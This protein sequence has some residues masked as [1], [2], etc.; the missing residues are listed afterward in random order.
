MV[1]LLGIDIGTSACKTAL[2]D[3]QG[4]VLA[5][6]TQSYPLF[7][8]H[9]GWAEQNPEDF[10]DAV[11]RSIKEV[12]GISRINPASIAGIGVDGQSWSAIAVDGEGRVLCPD[13]IWMDN[14]AADICR[15]MDPELRER[16]IRVSG[17]PLTANYVTGKLLW[18]RENLPD[19]Y[20]NTA[21]ILQSEGYINYRLTGR[22]TM[23]RG[24]GY[25]FHC[26]DIAGGTWDLSVC[27][28]IGISADILP[29]LFDGSDIIGRV[30]A[31]AAKE[32]GLCEGTP[33]AAGSVDSACAPLGA[34]VIHPGE[35]QEQG[36]QSGGMSICVSE[37]TPDSRLIL[38]NHAIPG[39]WLL[40]GGTVGGGG[41]IR[42]AASEFG[43]YEETLAA[44]TG[45]SVPAQFDIEA[46]KAPAGSD[47]LI[48][49]PYMSGERTPI[50]DP[51]AKGVFFGIDFSKTRGHFLRAA[52]E[53]VSYS[54]LH[55]LNVAAESGAKV[56]L[57]SATG[58]CANSRFWTQMKADMTGI[59]VSV[60]ESDNASGLGAAILAGV[61]T[62]VYS[63]FDDAVSRTVKEKRRHEPTPGMKEVYAANYEKYLKLYDSLKELMHA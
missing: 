24:E 48:F 61:G 44:D 38:C 23:N 41:V 29:E 34:G 55:N 62:G 56:T 16:L 49:L 50:W 51:D 19:V 25:G 27:D 9:P 40:Q 31:E 28:D 3:T 26:Y 39:R 33:V 10:W 4:N 47:G 37:P 54:L 21:A 20:K 2:F 8:P 60:P 57:M 53:G 45:L 52:M 42:W 36:G 12:L 6:S 30:S 35:T 63:D 17:N 13:P 18:Y 46:A 59:P 14:R 1:C 43:R 32:T 11:C 15:S 5:S 7:H 58:G 22:F